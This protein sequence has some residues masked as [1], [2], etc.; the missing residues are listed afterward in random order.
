MGS[1]GIREWIMRLM[2]INFRYM[3]RLGEHDLTTSSESESY[4]IPVD[5]KI[6][7]ERFNPK[8]IYSDIALLRLAQSAP[9]NAK[10]RPICLPLSDEHRNRDYTYYQ[11]FLAGWGATTYKGNQATVLQEV[12]LPIQPTKDC[13]D[14]Y[15]VHFPEQIFDDTVLCVGFINGGKDSCQG[16]S[17]GPLMLPQLAKESSYYYFNLLGIVSYGY[18]CARPGFPGIY[19]RV[20]SF[21]PWIIQHVND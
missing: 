13:E 4:D 21:I 10:V 16:D 8:I 15:K 12:Q 17:G 5:L 3:V 1:G 11:P 7:H 6:V 2:A 18:E 9:F 19:T 14:A 20:T